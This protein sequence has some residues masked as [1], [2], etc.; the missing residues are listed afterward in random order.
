MTL[1]HQDVYAKAYRFA[2]DVHNGQLLPGTELPYIVHVTLVAMEIVAAF[3]YEKD[4]DAELAVQCALLH[5][6]IEDTA[7]T[8][9]E[10]REAF[11]LRVAD[12]VLALSKDDKIEKTARMA[13]SLR[14][15]RTQSR[16]IWMVKMADR[17]TNLHLPFPSHWNHER[18]DAYQ[19]EA[20]AIHGELA[21]SSPY[22][23]ERME[24][25]IAR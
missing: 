4:H 6:V 18:I 17:I 5:D 25:L 2:A 9:G 15:I 13:D 1:W 12:G 21:E 7:T 16:E 24:A 10:V 3:Q 11:G 22:L 19:Q 23:A 8:Y 20:V 14:R